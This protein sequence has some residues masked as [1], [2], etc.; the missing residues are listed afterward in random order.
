MQLRM[1]TC[2]RCRKSAR[3]LRKSDAAIA[4]SREL[5]IVIGDNGRQQAGR[6]GGAGIFADAVL[7]AR[8]LHCSLT[9]VRRRQRIQLSLRD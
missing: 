3:R 1:P 6:V 5:R 7:A 8:L 2:D 4:E 9:A